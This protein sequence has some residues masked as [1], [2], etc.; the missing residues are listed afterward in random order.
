MLG[1]MQPIGREIVVRV[2]LARALRSSKRAVFVEEG[3]PKRQAK[4][5]EK[6]VTSP[7]DT[8][9]VSPV[10]EKSGRC[11]GVTAAGTR[12]KRNG[13]FNGYCASHAR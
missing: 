13:K 10:E 12:C 6:K 5:R 2:I 3:T 8:K 4:D 7:V 11:Q 1:H 9:V